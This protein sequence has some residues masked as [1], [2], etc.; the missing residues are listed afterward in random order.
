[1]HEATSNSREIDF[2]ETYVPVVQWTTVYPM[3]ILK[4]LLGL[5]SK[6]GNVTTAFL[7]S[8]IPEGEKVYVD[9]PCGFE[10][11]SKNGRKKT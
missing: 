7:H 8:E 10:Q 3:L 9:L 1:M 2:F 11:F 6:Q 4:V 5:K